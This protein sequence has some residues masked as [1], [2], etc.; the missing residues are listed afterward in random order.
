MKIQEAINKKILILDGAM[1]TMIQLHGLSEAEYRGDVFKDHSTSLMGFNDILNLTK[2][3]LVKDLHLKYLK[4]GADII[5]TN[6]FNAN[7]Y[8]LKEYNLEGHVYDI[9][10]HGAKLARD[11][12][13]NYSKETGKKNCYVVGVLGPTGTTASISPSINN[14]AHREVTFDDLAEAYSKQVEG[15]IDAGVDVLMVETIFDTLNAKAALYAINELLLKT[16]INIPVIASVTIDESGRNLSGQ[17]VEAFYNSL[18]P[19]SLFSIGLNCSFGADKITPYLERLSVKAELPVSA[20]PNAGLPN[21]LGDYDQSPA[22]MAELLEKFCEKGLVNIVGGCCGSKPEHIEAI[23]NMAANYKPRKIPKNPKTTRLS[24]LQS[25][26]VKDSTKLIKIGERTNVTGSKKFARLIQNENYEEALQIARNQIQD[27]AEMLNINLDESM[28]DGRKVMKVFLNYLSAEPDI[29][30]VPVMIDSSDFEVIQNGLKCLQGR[31]VVN[32]ISLKDG[33]EQFKQKAELIKKLGAVIVV[34]AF[35]EKGQAESYKRKIEICERAYNILTREI[36]IPPEDIIFDPNVLTIGTGIEQHNNYGVDFIKTV[37]WIKKKLPYAKVNAGVSNVSFSFRGNNYLRDVINSVFVHHCEKAGLDFAIVNPAK[38]F[39]YNDIPEEIRIPVEDL[40]LNRRKD[41]TDRLVD[42]AGKYTPEQKTTKSIDQWRKKPVNERIVYAFCNGIN[43]HI[44]EDVGELKL[45]YDNV[46]EIIQGPLMDGMNRVGELFS[47]GKMFLPQVIKSARLMNK[48]VDM[49][50]EDIEKQSKKAGKKTHVKKKILLATVEGDVHDIGKNIVALVLRCN[51][52]EVIDLGIMVPNKKIVEAVENEKPDLVG[53]SGL[54]SPSLEKMQDIIKR[55]EKSSYK[56]PV[57]LGGA[58]TSAIHTAVKIAPHYSGTVVQV[59]D[60]T[61]SITVANSLTTSKAKTVINSIKE[62]QEQLRNDFQQKKTKTG[63][64]S[65]KEARKRRYRYNSEKPVKPKMLGTKEF[66]DFD[67]GQLRSYIDWTPFFHGWG[68]K[69]KYPSIFEK[70]RV[71]NEAERLFK[72]ANAMLDDIE[73]NKIIKPKG[74]IGIFPANSREDD[75]LVF[76]DDERKKI[77]MEIPMLRQQQLKNDG[78][79]LSLADFIAPVD[80][81]IKDYFGGFAVTTGIGIEKYVQRFKENGDSYKSI[82]FRLIAD[83]LVEA[84]AEIMHEWVRK[85]YWGY[86]PDENLGIE[87]LI[88]GKYKGIRPAV[89]YPAC[90]DHS[91]KKYLFE[92]MNVEDRIGISLTDIYAMK[93]ASSVSGFYLAHNASRY[94][95]IGKIGK[96]QVNDYADRTGLDVEKAEKWL[97]FAIDK[98]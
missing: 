77:V 12:A 1:G 23:A 40:V 82:M 50:S 80:S 44:E 43:K 19:F 28:I 22:E 14:P 5:T 91:L 18:S 34:M 2:P 89:G 17:T 84:A 69:G 4:A 93:P 74:I 78:Y 63:F 76:K 67:I 48:A 90:P 9:N 35:D 86:V 46:L 7:Y 64:L 72:E 30:N 16:S 21:E 33:E 37:K 70:E 15:L 59:P 57:L 27:G 92:L 24:G 85:K 88:K 60:A 8:G 95:G 42:I 39:N 51:N 97:Y 29:V 26:G 66:K 83:R 25:F 13:D 54:I 6:T 56:V 41:A 71:G 55:F 87:E 94:F 45:N 62:Q 79:T 3:G 20:H 11:A 52:Y 96:D 49:L 98:Q 65:L 38:I 10:Y 68:L 58:A 47:R 31:S 75:V 36:G 32:S 61:K 81:G 53:L 73:K